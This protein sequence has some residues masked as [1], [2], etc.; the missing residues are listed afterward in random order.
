VLTSSSRQGWHKRAVIKDVQN[1]FNSFSVIG[2]NELTDIVK[3]IISEA[4]KET[5]VE[6][7]DQMEDKRFIE[8]VNRA[9][10]CN[11]GKK[12]FADHPK[13]LN[14]NKKVKSYSVMRNSGVAANAL[15]NA[16]YKCEYCVTHETFIRKSN[17]KPYTEPHHL[18]PMKYQ[19][20]FKVSL[21]VENN[22][23]SLCSN[24]HNRLHYGANI[25]EVLEILYS[26]RKLL[27]EMAGIKITYE[28]LKKYYQS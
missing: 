19:Q 10:Q 17:G 27:L 3:E 25:D 14:E 26:K 13:E 15:C 7:A 20:N 12:T 11:V 21:D 22:I 9:V 5:E 28:D 24:C 1:I 6:I 2:Y 8:D 4:E 23:V 16:D 18:I